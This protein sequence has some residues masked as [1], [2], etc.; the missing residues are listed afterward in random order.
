MN[1]NRFLGVNS[2]S[3]YIFELDIILD[4]SHHVLK[5]ITFSL[6]AMLTLKNNW[7]VYVTSR[8]KKFTKGKYL[9]K[10]KAFLLYREG[11]VMQYYV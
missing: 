6:P 2:I 7:W 9:R 5:C 8:Y 3:T 4:D 1:E 11:S 10:G